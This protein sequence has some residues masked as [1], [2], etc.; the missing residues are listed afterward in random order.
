MKAL[1]RLLCRRRFAALTT[2]IVLLMTGVLAVFAQQVEHDDDI[3]AFLPEGNEDVSVFRTINERFGGLDV[4]LIGIEAGDG[5]FTAAFLERLRAATEALND[6]EQVSYALSIANLEDLTADLEHGGIELK[7]LID[8]LP[9]N[10]AETAALREKVLSRDTARGNLVSADGRAVLI[11]CFAGYG[12]DP[13][14]IAQQIRSVVSEHFPD[15]PT[16]WG[17][18]PFISTYIYD[19]T[20]EE[21]ARLTPW[22]VIAILVILLI[23][24]RDLIGTVLALLTTGMGIAVAHGL[25]ALLGV[26]FNIVLSSMPIILF[27]VGSA[28]S[29]HILAHYYALEP[30]LGVEKAIQA[31]LEHLGPVVLAAGLTTVAGLLS[32]VMM[33]IEPMR[34]FGLFTALGILSTLI[35]SITFVPAVIR[36]TG[37][38]RKNSG[39]WTI[40]STMSNL[41]ATAQRERRWVGVILLACGLVAAFHAGRVDARMDHGSFF[42]SGS[43]PDLAERFLGEHFGGSQFIQVHAQ[44]DLKDPLVLR[45]LRRVADRLSLLPYVTDV[46]HIGDAL[47]VANEALEGMRRIP[48]TREKVGLLYGFVT[49][50][51][52]LAQLVDDERTEALLQIK[53]NATRADQLEPLLEEVERWV[54][55]ESLQHYRRAREEEGDS[56]SGAIS[57]RRLELVVS[58]IS[59]LAHEYKVPVDELKKQ[60]LVA[61]LSQGNVQPEA[62]SVQQG[63]GRFLRSN[64][65]IVQLPDDERRLIDTVAARLTSLGPGPDEFALLT[66]LQGVLDPGVLAALELEDLAFS[67]ATPIQELWTLARARAVAD[68]LVREGE[69]LLPTGPHGER[70]LLRLATAAIDLHN[71][72]VLLPAAS[73]GTASQT[74]ES[75]SGRI[76]LRVN[77]LPVLHRGLSRSVTRNQFRSLGF[78]LSLVLVLMIG[79]FRSV[80]AGC[81][82]T[83]PTAVTL[84]FVFGGMGALD[85]HLDIGTSMLASIIIGAGVDYGVHLLAGWHSGEQ[86]SGGPARNSS[87][88]AAARNAALQT[89][90]A[91][92][93]NAIMVAAGFFVLTLGEAKPLQNVGSLTAA[94]M[95]IAGAATF[96]VVPVLARRD[97]YTGAYVVPRPEGDPT[98]E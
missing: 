50:N 80:T 21:M 61:I 32:F 49:G 25:M 30:K 26:K 37:L 51:R 67:V 18:A 38:R 2:A 72:E 89:S 92:W 31:T 5:L 55:A 68:S 3:L 46:L 45:E 77:G 76:Q 47:A 48:D 28:Y 17:G 12:S 1:A 56:T 97:R 83:A 24:F 33:D 43:P 81:L 6:L 71:D 22:A 9:Q 35:L 44:G 40:S 78:A 96:V 90:P 64:E 19:T 75:G 82:A 20:E 34:T 63:L 42:S 91:I 59:A 41:A 74:D 88:E 4:A 95:L 36:L 15:Q 66:T 65:C 54:A 93:T 16:Y 94:A 23:T 57:A 29:I 10:P 70:F 60:K 73:N 27:A 53:V 62:M 11:Y 14:G 52:A 8:A 86:A 85:V 39:R 79:F 87:I 69:L 13:R 58:R 98:L 84:L 7:T